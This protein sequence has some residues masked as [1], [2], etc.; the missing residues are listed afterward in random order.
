MRHRVTHRTGSGIAS[1]H[2]GLARVV[3]IG[4]SWLKAQGGGSSGYDL[5]VL[6]LTSGAH[7]SPRP[8]FFL[9]GGIHAREYVTAETALRFAE[10]KW[11][12]FG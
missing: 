2:P 8:A 11:V 3:D 5:R 6:V 7:P 4:D 1:D 12:P 9:M 10:H